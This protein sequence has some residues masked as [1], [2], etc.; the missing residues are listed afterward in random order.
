MSVWKFR[1]RRRYRP[2]VP[3]EIYISI[4]DS[5][6]SD[7]RSL[8]MGAI[9]VSLAI[10]VTAVKVGEPLLYFCAAAV[11][12]VAFARAIGV[13][14]YHRQRPGMK[15]AQD[16]GRWEL[17]YAVGTSALIALLG[18]WCVVAFGKTSDPFVQL[19]S[20]TST[21]AY[22][23][24]VT[25]RNFGSSRLVVAQILC[26]APLT[27]LSLWLTGD[28]YYA[29]YSVL[30]VSFFFA[31]KFISD[32]L[33]KTLMDAVI[34]ARD[35]TLL[36]NRFDA[37]LNNMPLGLCMFDAERRLVVINHRGTEL[38]GVP[39]NET[40]QGASARDLFQAASRAGVFTPANA[41]RIAAE[42]E[43]GP[44]GRGDDDIEVEAQNGR[45][46]ALTFQP[47]ANRG[48]V[49]MIEDITE[50]KSAAAKIHYLARYDALTGLPNRTF[51]HQKM[52]V[53]LARQQKTGESCAVL[54][55]DLD[56]FKQI[57]DT[58]GHPFGDALLCVVAERLRRIARPS[59]IVAR[60]GG[61]EFVILQYPIEAP[62]DA[63][64]LARR[65]AATLG[66][67][68][69]IDHHQVVIG[70]SIGISIGLQD[71]DNADLLLKNADM[72]LYRT[73]SE[74]RG[75]WRFFETEM[76]VK[77]QARRSLEIDL[78]NAVATEAFKVYYQPLVDLKTRRIS[79]C[80]ALLRW[81]HPERGM[82]SPAEFI[83]L[84]E[85]MGLIVEI[86]D[87]VL[88]ESCK[89]CMQWPT[90][91]RVAVNLS[92][93]QF[94]RGNV[95]SVVSEALKLSGLPA[96]RLE[97]EI[98]E[99]V[100]IQDTETTR[101]YLN[102]LREMGVR[103]SLDDFGTGYSSLSYL[104]SFPL[105]KVKIDRSFLQG[106]G[107]S[108]RSRILLRGVAR[109]SAELGMSVVVEGVETDDELDLIVSEA[110]VDEAQGYL[111]SP[112]IPSS[113]IRRMLESPKVAKF[114]VA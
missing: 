94:R 13:R 114:K 59:D 7:T 66:E 107:K 24:G 82:V 35:N 96:N 89:E 88:R 49:V 69:A 34:A 81:P 22:L 10:L 65:V 28:A 113:A 40:Y 52:Q 97:L 95:V 21:V 112:A 83:P 36:A 2:D 70:A 17:Q 77:A 75:A 47:M 26:A 27:V 101:K 103:I 67:P 68:C 15:T 90:D 6:Y 33:R 30:F 104:H 32:R 51:F 46:F 93:I 61:D 60:F 91:T 11:S 41:S 86:G 76:D 64:S 8:F 80:E 92:P 71:G 29:I 23:I 45:T 79:T 42:I 39:G 58:M 108:E 99:S 38:L 43:T 111:F 4:V 102:E 1:S 109:L 19:V 57:N 53:T 62:E 72:A 48:S 78:R 12:A 110:N 14:A 74:G 20:I 73:K 55:I 9:A 87:Y 54:F 85:E 44:T 25:G 84:A 18:I 5:L 16:A 50:R 56:Q 3:A 63:A 106:I 100:L 98:T 37:A 31:M 105:N